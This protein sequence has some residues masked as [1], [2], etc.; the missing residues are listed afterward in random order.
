[1]Y[2]LYMYVRLAAFVGGYGWIE[3]TVVVIPAQGELQQRVYI[4]IHMYIYIC[5]FIHPL[6]CRWALLEESSPFIRPVTRSPRTLGQPPLG[7][8]CARSDSG[9]SSV[10]E[11]RGSR[12][13]C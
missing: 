8:S 11:W 7:S 2:I 3:L 5:I 1:M 6:L 10:A 13:C 9:R 4:H 12:R